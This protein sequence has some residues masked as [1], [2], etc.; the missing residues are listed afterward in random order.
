[1]NLHVFG[2]GEVGINYEWNTRNL[3]PSYYSHSC[4]DKWGWKNRFGC[5]FLKTLCCNTYTKFYK[6]FTRVGQNYEF[7]L[8]S[9]KE[10][11]KKILVEN[12]VFI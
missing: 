1:M 5:F 9:L 10:L 11:K 6:I 2:K 12:K 8:T 7:I 4:E 3:L